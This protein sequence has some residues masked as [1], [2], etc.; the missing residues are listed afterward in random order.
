MDI[1]GYN[2]DFFHLKRKSF[3]IDKPSEFVIMR[4]GRFRGIVCGRSD[5]FIEQSSEDPRPQ[6]RRWRKMSSALGSLRT[7]RFFVWSGPK[8]SDLFRNGF[9][10]H[11]AFRGRMTSTKAERP[12]EKI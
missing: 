2:T 9:R 7:E 3:P 10:N 4:V 8:I 11:S 6:P 12:L 1:M 5:S